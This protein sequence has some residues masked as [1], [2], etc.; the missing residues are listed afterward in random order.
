MDGGSVRAFVGR[1]TELAILRGALADANAGRPQVVLIEGEA[2]IG[3]TALLREGARTARDA[4]LVWVSGDQAEQVIEFG[5]ATQLLAGMAAAVTPSPGADRFMVGGALLDALG[6]LEEHGTVVLVVDDLQWVDPA[7]FGALLFCVRRLRIDPVLV[8]L[9]CRPGTLDTDDGGWSG[10]LA[11]SEHAQRIRLEGLTPREVGELALLGGRHLVRDTATRLTRHT[12]GNPLYLSALLDELPADVLGDAAV[13]L[14]APRAYATSVLAR[15]ARLTPPARELVCAAAVLGVH[16][17]LRTAATVAGLSPTSPA[18][19]EAIGA[20]LLD[21]GP[22]GQ[23]LRFAHPLMRAA[24]YDDLP[25]STRRRMHLAAAPLVPRQ[26]GFAHRVRAASGEYDATLATDLLT[27]ADAAQED[28]AF[29][30]AARQLIA[31]W[32]VDVDRSRAERSLFEAVRLRLMTGD[33]HGARQHAAAVGSC[34]PSPWRRYTQALFAVVEGRLEHGTAELTA[35]ADSSTDPTLTGYCAADLA[36]LCSSLGDYA[37]GICW[38]ERAEHMATTPA[39]R[40]TA[41]QA[42]SWGHARLGRFAQA[43]DALSGCS[44]LTRRPTGLDAQFLAVRGVQRNWSGDDAGAIEDLTAVLR[45][46]R[47]GVSSTSIIDAYAA[48]A[49]AEFRCGDWAAAL[50]HIDLGLSLAVD[51][52]QTWF[53]AYA[54]SVATQVHA[55]RGDLPLAAEH[56]A[57]AAAAA[58]AQPNYEA[59]G[60]A[61]LAAV[62]VAWAGRDWDGIVAAVRPLAD[63]SATSP[64]SH[65]NLA[66]WRHRLAEAHLHLGHAADA[67]RVRDEIA[68]RPWGGVD[69]ADLVRLDARLQLSDG[70]P[71]AAARSYTEAMPPPTSRRLA[72]GLLAL[73][74]GRFLLSA[75]HRKPAAA[76]LQT[77]RTILGGLGAGRLAADADR[78]LR[79]CGV[80]ASR[81]V[82]APSRLDLLTPR[83]QTV[84]RLVATGMT[85]REIAAE[86]YV[87]V[88]TVEYHLSGIFTTLG[89]HSRRQLGPVLSPIS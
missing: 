41:L 37:A 88:K 8:L 48:L 45:W 76:A 52:D 85:N 70:D 15:L 38:A 7:S 4:A 34:S 56:A 3:K 47:R 73:D 69:P 26:S 79:S 44:P 82:D 74:H 24:V 80:P 60:Y 72:D 86:L 46:Q 33:V 22:A 9:A 81:V 2:G 66:L 67:H 40:A 13:S 89:I 21:L 78:S 63:D 64:G 50:L 6:A 28:G 31:A 62:Q 57:A 83:E 27:S 43:V 20:G 42:L 75:H 68:D 17:P 55:A 58:H 10:F 19:D 36:L 11:G 12:G 54:E 53:L 5:A 61:A 14:P 59:F 87:S 84:A 23:E 39:A 71:A 49:E 25:P 29:A 18:L 77:A 30:R 35:L 51:L 65:P 32:Q 1:P 16:A